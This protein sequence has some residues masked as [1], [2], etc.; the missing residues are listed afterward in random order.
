[1]RGNDDFLVN[2]TGFCYAKP[3]LGHTITAT[4]RRPTGP[5]LTVYFDLTAMHEFEVGAFFIALLMHPTE[6]EIGKRRDAFIALCAAFAAEQVRS[7]PTEAAY[8]REGRPEYFSVA[9]KDCRRVLKQSKTL[10]RYRMLA[11]VMARP[12]IG[13]AKFGDR[14]K[15]PK[16]LGVLRPEN[17]AAYISAKHNIMAGENLMQ[18]AWRPSL[19]IL[20]LA[21]GLEHAIAKRGSPAADI[22]D[23]ETLIEP[24]DLALDLQDI[25]LF[26][27]AVKYSSEAA[28]VIRRDARIRISDS[29]I[30]DIRWVE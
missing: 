21:I 3:V 16:E 6:R 14:Y 20:S 10:L 29:D 15:L 19:P 26:R 13:Q 11:A 2:Q 9:S 22:V 1:M 8:L 17:C 25:D 18:R 27:A 24:H 12:F 28:D 30:V 23:L 4:F 5:G 7:V